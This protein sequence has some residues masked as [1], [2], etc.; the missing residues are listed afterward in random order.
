VALPSSGS[1]SKPSRYLFCSLLLVSC[2]AFFSTWKMDAVRS[3]QLSV[4]FHRTTRRHIPED[5]ILPSAIDSYL[6]VEENLLLWIRRLII[7][8][9][10]PV[11]ASLLNSVLNFTTY[12]SEFQLYEFPR[13]KCTMN[14]TCPAQLTLT[15][16]C[17]ECRFKRFLAM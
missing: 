16:L 7:I 14:A 12:L 10:K 5:R 15:T 2:L 17:K 3:S 6:V 8:V 11:I 4:N 1:K 13:R 9:T